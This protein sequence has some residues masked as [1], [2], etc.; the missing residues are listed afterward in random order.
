MPFTGQPVSNLSHGATDENVQRREASLQDRTGRA[1]HIHVAELNG[2]DCERRRRQ[3][4]ANLVYKKPDPLLDLIILPLKHLGVALGTEFQNCISD[5]IVEA[6]VQGP[7]LNH[8][9]RCVTLERQVRDGLTEITVVV[10]YLVYRIAQ[11]QETR[12]V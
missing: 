7:K 3:S 12:P 6:P 8:R 11:A 2:T 10:D 4:I 5:C 1:A 9:E